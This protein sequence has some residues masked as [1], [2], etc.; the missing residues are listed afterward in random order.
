MI[1]LLI[2]VCYLTRLGG[3]NNTI[4]A[5]EEN[6]GQIPIVL[7]VRTLRNARE[8]VRLMVIDGFSTPRIRRYLNAWLAWWV[9]TS[10]SLSPHA[11]L[12]QFIQTCRDNIIS[13]IAT[14][15]L[16]TKLQ[17]RGAPV[18]LQPSLENLATV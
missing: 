8:Q 13:R 4:I 9:R 14:G 7:H 6:P 17:A 5:D 16:L 12:S 1:D 11:V 18:Q 3:N 2:S 15:L 10:Q